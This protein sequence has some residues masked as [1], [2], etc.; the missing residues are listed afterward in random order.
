MPGIEPQCPQLQ[1]PGML[2]G[3]EVTKQENWVSSSITCTSSLITASY[4]PVAVHQIHSLFSSALLKK[5]TIPLVGKKNP[6]ILL[7]LKIN[8][9]ILK[10]QPLNPV[11]SKLHILSWQTQTLHPLVLIRIL[12]PTPLFRNLILKNINFRSLPD[13]LVSIFLGWEMLCTKSF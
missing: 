2:K 13:M 7:N 8:Y 11:M 12:F 1:I 9:H 3:H 4:F 10:D 6:C 5:L